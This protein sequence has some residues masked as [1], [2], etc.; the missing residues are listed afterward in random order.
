MCAKF[1]AFNPKCTIV[2]KMAVNSP[3]KNV[4]VYLYKLTLIYYIKSDTCCI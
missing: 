3:I 4:I 2:P 1:H